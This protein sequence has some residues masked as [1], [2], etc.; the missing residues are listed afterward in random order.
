MG[1]ADENSIVYP[2]RTGE[3]FADTLSTTHAIFKTP[4]EWRGRKVLFRATGDDFWLL[5][6]P[7]ITVEVDRTADSTVNGTTKVMTVD[8]TTGVHIPV[9]TYYECDIDSIGGVDNYFSCEGAS[10]DSRFEAHRTSR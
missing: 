10:S 5:F 8:A 7:L 2:P 1:T 3:V 9:N 4:D 6:G